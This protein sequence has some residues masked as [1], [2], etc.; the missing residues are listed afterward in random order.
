VRGTKSKVTHVIGDVAE[1]ACLIIDDMISTGSTIAESIRALLAAGARP[2]IRIAATHGV[3][4]LDARRKLD[5][6][7]VQ[8]VLSPIQYQYARVTGRNCVSPQ[9]PR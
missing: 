4:V 7:A 9:S 1:W 6:P 3:F 2:E 5:H 8:E